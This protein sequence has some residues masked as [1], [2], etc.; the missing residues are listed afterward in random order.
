MNTE[1]DF[2]NLVEVLEDQEDMV[3]CK[4]CFDLFPKA[5]CAKQ[6]IGYLCPTCGKMSRTQT[7]VSPAEYSVFDTY[8]QEFPDVQEYDPGTTKDY[9]EEPKL[10]DAL[11]D[12]IKDEYDAI[13]AYE[14]A[15]ETIQHLPMDED[16]KDDILD[17]IDHIKEEEEEHIEELKDLAG[18]DQKEEDT[19]EDD[20]EEIEE[21]ADKQTLAESGNLPIW[22]GYTLDG[23][24]F[25]GAVRAATEEDAFR[26]LEQEY[27]ATWVPMG[28]EPDE[29]VVELAEDDVEFDETDF[30]GERDFFQRAPLTEASKTEPVTLTTLCDQGS[31]YGGKGYEIAIVDPTDK[32]SAETADKKYNR[33]I[34]KTAK[35]GV[36][37]VV[38]VAKLY[39]NAA[40]SLRGLYDEAKTKV[41]PNG[42]EIIK[43]FK[44]TD[45]KILEYKAG[46]KNL[47]RFKEIEKQLKVWAKNSKGLEGGQEAKPT[48]TENKPSEVLQFYTQGVGKATTSVMDKIFINGYKMI[49]VLQSTFGPRFEYVTDSTV[50]KTIVEA[51]KAVQA[52]SKSHA[53]YE[54][55]GSNTR[56]FYGIIANKVTAEDL[57]K[58]GFETEKATEAL[59]AL[60]TIINRKLATSYIKTSD[61][62]DLSHSSISVTLAAD[63]DVFI[64]A[65]MDGRRPMPTQ[66]DDNLTNFVSGAEKINEIL[67]EP[68][69][70]EDPPSTGDLDPEAL[71]DKIIKAIT[72]SKEAKKAEEYTEESFTAYSTAVEEHI[73]DGG[74]IKSCSSVDDLKALGFENFEDDDIEK[75]IQEKLDSLLKKPDT[76][77]P[78]EEDPKKETDSANSKLTINQ[79]TSLIYGA[80]Q[81]YGQTPEKKVINRIRD[82]LKKHLGESLGTEEEVRKLITEALET[83]KIGEDLI[84]AE[85]TKEAI[86]ETFERTPEAMNA[87]AIQSMNRDTVSKV[88]S[89]VKNINQMF[90]VFEDTDPENLKEEYH[91][92]ANQAEL[93]AMEDLEAIIEAAKNEALGLMHGWG[94]DITE[95][96]AQGWMSG[97]KEYTYQFMLDYDGIDEDEEEDVQDQLQN[98]VEN[99]ILSKYTLPPELSKINISVMLPD[100]DLSDD[101]WDD[102]EDEGAKRASLLVDVTFA[103]KLL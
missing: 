22:A 20:E 75:Y 94:I 63:E 92:Y 37:A 95:S 6:D 13:D 69:K 76:P 28:Y 89:A 43:L 23:G 46:K 47:D 83:G 14:V 17:T 31:A 88:Q 4:E 64:C 2:E 18:E 42:P 74:K 26:I 103:R 33:S 32:D 99:A 58:A 40:V 100:P 90:S 101:D 12:L 80:F 34:W 25:V 1:L 55:S 36:N 49:T 102:E 71:K 7:M 60:E 66:G 73:S 56:N 59:K 29:L 57:T 78:P 68:K 10:E 8:D 54:P 41:L 50:Y 70:Q 67:G 72:A 91:K 11:A 61:G 62:K 16:E 82:L 44:N 3:E 97:N 87:S 38:K 52:E 35:E 5:E 93:K 53:Y 21:S 19:E 51:Y 81:K 48:P 86:T 77:E 15:D 9:D 96:D 84:T 98:M 24:E 85:D 27:V 30:I 65:L 79:I 45:N 39:P